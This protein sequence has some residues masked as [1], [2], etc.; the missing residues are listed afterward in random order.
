MEAGRIRLKYDLRLAVFPTQPCNTQFSK[1][2]M[3]ISLFI[4]LAAT[5]FARR[6]FIKKQII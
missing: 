6:N 1:E 5:V 2:K 3:N 4:F